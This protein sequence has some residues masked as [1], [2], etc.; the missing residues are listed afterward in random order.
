MGAF[1]N[2]HKRVW[3]PFVYCTLLS[4]DGRFLMRIKPRRPKPARNRLLRSVVT[5]QPV[6]C[7]YRFQCCVELD[8]NKLDK[9]LKTVSIFTKVRGRLKIAMAF[10][11]QPGLQTGVYVNNFCCKVAGTAALRALVSRLRGGERRA[12]DGSALGPRLIW[13][14]GDTSTECSCVTASAAPFARGV[15]AGGAGP[16]ATYAALSNRSSTAPARAGSVDVSLFFRQRRE[17]Y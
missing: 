2:L 4:I 13:G 9:K 6:A 15:H 16:H 14:G 12:L 5:V 1:Q 17:L 7:R 3:C 11:L 10:C 8:R